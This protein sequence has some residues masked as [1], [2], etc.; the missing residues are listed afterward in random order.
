VCYDISDER[1]L[2]RVAKVMEDYGVRVL[3]SVF[4]CVLSREEFDEMKQRAESV[5]DLTED[6]MRYYRLC[7][8]CCKVYRH[9]GYGRK[10]R[11]EDS[12]VMII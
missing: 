2:R 4:E 3:Y 8:R 11:A 7:S 5:M 6:K 12:D 1:R 10:A 9:L